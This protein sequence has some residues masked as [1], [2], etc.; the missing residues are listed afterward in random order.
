MSNETPKIFF[1]TSSEDIQAVHELLNAKVHCH[2]NGPI[3]EERTPFLVHGSMKF[4][5][6]DGIRE[7]IK[8]ER[9]I[10]QK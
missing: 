7:F 2:F 5:G 9:K 8:R 4:Y 3:T 6:I 1:N 10:G